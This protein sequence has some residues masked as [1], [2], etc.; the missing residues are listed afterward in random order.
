MKKFLPI[1]LSILLICTISVGFADGKDTVYNISDAEYEA[2]YQAWNEAEEL[3]YINANQNNPLRFAIREVENG[4]FTID[5]TY[6]PDMLSQHL[7]E[8]Q[9]HDFRTY[10]NNQYISLDIAIDDGPWLSS[11]SEY[12]GPMLNVIQYELVS[13]TLITTE[14]TWSIFNTNHP[15]SE[16]DDM[17]SPLMQ[18]FDTA[19]GYY[20]LDLTQHKVHIRYKYVFEV[21]NSVFMSMYSNPVTLQQYTE[22]TMPKNVSAPNVISPVAS[23]ESAQ[24]TFRLEESGEVA[25][26]KALGH[27]F[28]VKVTILVNDKQTNSATVSSDTLYHTYDIKYKDLTISDVVT[29]EVSYYNRTTKTESPKQTATC[30]LQITPTVIA[31]TLPDNST[32][33]PDTTTQAICSVCHNCSVQPLGMCLWIFCAACVT[34]TITL[35][36]GIIL[37]VSNKQKTLNK[38]KTHA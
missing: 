3:G 32:Q 34:A 6:T 14:T 25:A 5:A 37:L 16:D 27:E 22:E 12:Y 19:T 11:H 31:P 35:V 26:L 30:G 15:V 9:Y 1:L 7:I 10:L 23:T 24:V 8:N 18:Y 17:T 29:V 38:E 20:R 2:M 36:S 28:D 4:V 21:G 33:E 13:K